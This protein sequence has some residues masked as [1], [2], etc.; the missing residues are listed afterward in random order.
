MPV[1]STRFIP[2]LPE[3]PLYP[4]YKSTVVGQLPG[5]RPQAAPFLG[6]TLF[7]GNGPCL[8]WPIFGETFGDGLG[9]VNNS[10]FALARQDWL[11]RPH[12]PRPHPIQP[13]NCPWQAVSQTASP[14]LSFPWAKYSTANT[15]PCGSCL[16]ILGETFRGKPTV[17]IEVILRCLWAQG[18]QHLPLLWFKTFTGG[19]RFSTG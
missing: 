14:T 10:E 8:V 2:W 7:L 16:C 19:Q 15:S 13:T 11:T 3:T 1:R 17:F 12:V 5:R 4:T 9:T 18:G 6:H